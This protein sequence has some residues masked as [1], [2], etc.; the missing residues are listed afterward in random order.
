MGNVLEIYEIVALFTVDPLIAVL[1]KSIHL[2][3]VC[4]RWS[5][6]QQSCHLCVTSSTDRLKSYISLKFEEDKY[7]E[8][9]DGL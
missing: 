7:L 1:Y 6:H 2:F 5:E 3:S 9:S 4:N 8:H